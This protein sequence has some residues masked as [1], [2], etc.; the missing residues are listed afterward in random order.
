ML[1]KAL[2]S[3]RL[4]VFVTARWVNGGWNPEVERAVLAFLFFSVTAAR[5]LRVPL[6]MGSCGPLWAQW[7]TLWQS[8]LGTG[9]KG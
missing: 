8:L 9:I 3:I 2:E 7:F 6:T 4:S 5:H 1:P